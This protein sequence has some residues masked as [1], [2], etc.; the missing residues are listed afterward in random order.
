[1][2]NKH[3]S[4]GRKRASV[5]VYRAAMRR[6]KER[7]TKPLTPLELA[8]AAAGGASRARIYA[9]LN[10][11]LSEQA[12]EARVERRGG[13]RLL[14]D[15]QER[16]LV[17]FAVSTRTSLQP[18]TLTDLGKFCHSHFGVRPSICTLS[19]TMSSHGLSSQKAMTRNSR[20]TS[21]LVVEDALLTI[22]EIRSYNFPPRRLIFMDETGLWSNVRAPK[23]Y[24]FRNWYDILT[25]FSFC[26]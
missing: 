22:E 23:T 17:G 7:S 20:M 19:E 10:E 5:D 2:S 8:R 18:V 1:M 26:L 25:S 13:R 9:W 11:D 24:H 6:R 4:I 15:D 21:Q 16:L 3:Y 12:V 14:T